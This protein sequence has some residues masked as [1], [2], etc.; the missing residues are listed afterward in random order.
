MTQRNIDS[1]IKNALL[2]ND[3]FI[4]AHLVKFER[5]YDQIS[6]GVYPTDGERYAYYTDGATD[7]VFNDG[8]GEQTYR[9]N[10]IQSVGQYSETTRARA[11]T[12]S[13]VLAGED[14]GGEVAVTGTITAT[15]S[16]TGFITATSTVVNGEALDF[17][18]Y[19]FKENDE[20]SVKYGS[21]S[22]IFRITGFTSNNTVIQIKSPG[23]ETN[24]VVQAQSSTTITIRQAS[25][26]L[27]AALQERST[28]ES[29]PRFVN[30][31][32]FIH[33]VFINPETGT[34]LGNKS[35]LVFK[36][37][38][39]S[40]NL[41]EGT[42]G[43]KVKWGL[44]SHWGDFEEVNG[45]LTT[46]ETHRA[47][48]A[49]NIPQ[50]SSVLRPEYAT[51]LGFMHSETSLS[52]IANYLTQETRYKSKQKKR[53]GVA[54][55]FGGKK[56]ELIEYQV[57][58][59]NEVDLNVHLQGKYLPIIYGVQRVNGNT[60]FADTLNNDDKA[61]Y[62]VDAICE[63]EIHGLFN[64]YIDDV[65]LICTDENDFDVRNAQSGTD[66]DNTQLQCFGKMSRGNTLAGTVYSGNS[67]NSNQVNSDFSVS[68]EKTMNV[69]DETGQNFS[70]LIPLNLDTQIGGNI[71]ALA[72][73]DASGL[74]HGATFNVE[75]PMSISHQFFHGRANQLASSILTNIAEFT[76]G[77]GSV[78]VIN[79]G[80]NF[81]GTPTITF[82]APPSGGVRATGT[83]RMGSSSTNDANQIRSITVS[84][85]GSGYVSRPTITISQSNKGASLRANMGGFKRQ[86]DYWEGNL[87]YWGPNHRLLDTAYAATKF[88]VDPDSTT[89]PEIEYVVKGKVLDSYNYDN[90]FVPDV[91]SG[92]TNSQANNFSEGDLVLVQY[93]DGSAWQDDTSG[94][95]TANKFKIMDKW[96]HTTSRGTTEYRFRLDTTPNLGIT[97]ATRRA[98]RT[99]LRFKDGSNF[100]YMLT[101][102]YSF[103]D[104]KTFPNEW[105]AIGNNIS[106]PSGVITLSSISAANKAIIGDDP[107][108]QFYD[109]AWYTT[110]SNSSSGLKYGIL[111]G[112][113]SGS[114]DA[115][116][117]TF[118]GTNYTNA[119][120]S[121]NLKI[122]NA[123]QY[124][125]ST[126]SE[127]AA[128]SNTA[129]LTSSFTDSQS[130]TIFAKGSILTNKNTGESREITSFNTT[131]NVLEIEAPFLTPAYS[132]HKFKID[133]RGADKRALSNPALQ[134]LDFIKD[135]KYGRGLKEDDLDIGSF[136]NSA[137]L[138]DARS[139]ITIKLASDPSGIAI[140]DIFKATTTGASNGAFLA[141]G[142]VSA[143]DTTNNTMTLTKVINKFAKKY[144][145]YTSIVTGDIVYRGDTGAYHR[146][147][148]NIPL[149]P[150]TFTG[151]NLG[152]A[153]SSVTLHKSSGTGSLSSI[154]MDIT[155]AIPIDYALYDS[156]WVKYWRYF[157]WE[158]HHQR[159][160]VRH[161]TNFILDTGKSVF[162]NINS[163]L[164][165]FNGI[166][167]YENG[168]YVLDVETQEAAPV[169]S[170]SNG[171]NQNPY[172]IDKTDII[173]N[174]TVN[175][176]SQKN[177]KNTIKASLADPQLNWGSRSV[178]FFNSNF[179][180]ADRNIVK[181]G[182]FPFT[183]I[184]NYYNARINTEKELFQSRFSKEVS[185][186]L[187][188]KAL[189]LRAG[190]VLSINYPPFEWSN[191]LFRIE[192]LSFQ[193]DCSVSV[194]CREY[195]DSI[196]EIT[197]QQ[198]SGV[199]SELSRQH[200]I[201]APAPPT[202]L[203]A[204]TN[205]AG[206]ILLSWS[207]SD[208]FLD[209]S[210]NTEVYCATSNDRSHASLQHLTT[211]T[212]ASTSYMYNAATDE[213]KYF[214]IKHTRTAKAVTGN[215]E[216]LVKSSFFPSG[217]TSGITGTS[218][219]L[220]GGGIGAKV[221]QLTSDDY[222]IV[223]NQ[224]GASPSPSNT[225]TLTADTQGFD[226]PHFLF[227]GSSQ[228]NG[229]AET[230]YGDGSA[231]A[232]DTH[233]FNVPSGHFTD[234]ISIKVSVQ[235]GTSGGEVAFDT[236]SIF[237]VKPGADSSDLADD[238]YTVICSNE[239]HTM[240]ANTAG[241]I[242]SFSGSGTRF[243]VFKGAT[244]LQG[245]IDSGNP[246]SGQYKI[247]ASGTN[248]T[249]SDAAGSSLD[250]KAVVFADHDTM[251]ATT[252]KIIYTISLEGTSNTVTKQQS[253]ATS[254]R[255]AT[256]GNAK[257]VVVTP[258]TNVMIQEVSN[259]VDVPDD[260]FTPSVIDIT[261][262]TANTTTDGTWTTNT[263]SLTNIVNGHA[264]PSCRV[265]SSTISDGM[266]VKYTLASADGS[267]E[268]ST[269]LH[270]VQ[271]QGKAIT[272][273]LTNEAHVFAA[274]T[275]GA[276]SDTSGSG[277]DIE[278]YQGSSKLDFDGAGTSNGHWKVVLAN[279][280]NIT[281]GA[282]STLGTGHGRSARVAAHTSP[283]TGTD[284]FV[285]TYTITGKS[286][287][288]AAFSFVKIQSL[289]KSKTGGT[290]G[291]GA[292]GQSNAI[293]YAYQRSATTLSSNPGAVT[294]SLTGTTSGTITTGSL[295]NGWSK[296]IPS[297]SNPLYVCAATAAGNGSTDTVA[298]NEWSSAVIL[299]N[300]G[301]D[302]DD[303]LNSATIFL[304]QNNNTGSAPSSLPSGAATY[305][306]ASSSLGNFAS[307][308][309][310]WSTTNPGVTDSNNYLWV[311]SATAVARTSTDVIPDS[312]WA[313]I[314]LLAQN[315]DEGS[316]GIRTAL[317]YA[318]QRSA[319]NVT[320]NP[321]DV[322][323]TL[324]SGLIT[325]PSNNN[326]GNSW[327][328]AIPATD[329]NPLY[330]CAASAAGTGTTD[331]IA[332][333]EWSS[334]VKFVEDGEQ[335]ATGNSVA[336]VAI[337]KQ[338]NVGV[339][340]PSISGTSN[341]NFTS[342][343][344]TSLPAGWS[345]TAPTFNYLKTIWQSE[346]A[347]TGTGTSNTVTWPAA[348]LYSP[349]FDLNPNIFQRSVN[350][351]STPS[352]AIANPPSGWSST[353]PSGSNPIWQSTGNFNFGLSG[354]TYNW[355]APQK[356]S[357]DTG[358]AG[359][360]SATIVLYKLTTSS[361]QPDHPNSVLTWNFANKAFTDD[362]SELDGWSVNE[363][364]SASDNNYIWSCSATA[365][366][367]TATDDIAVAEW[368]DEALIR[369]PK[370]VRTALGTLYHAGTTSSVTAAP[371][372]S[373]VSYNFD[374][375]VFS[376]SNFNGWSTNIPIP[377]YSHV[378]YKVTEATF[379]GTQTITLGTSRY[380]SELIK[381]P[382]G[383]FELEYDD[384]NDRFQ[385]KFGSDLL[386]NLNIPNDIKNSQI[387][388]S[389]LGGATTGSIPTFTSGSAV[390]TNG[391]APNGSTYRRTTTPNE[392]YTS[393]GSAW[394]LLTINTDT[395]FTLPAD[396]L[397]GTISVSGTT[398]TVPKNDG[399]SYTFETQDTNTVPTAASGS[400]LP[401][402][403]GLTVGE[404]FARDDGVLFIATAAD[405]WVE[406][407]NSTGDT[408]YSAG[409]GI[410]VSGTTINNSGVTQITA[411][412]N[413]SISAGTG[414]VTITATNT[415]LSDAQVRS[416]FSA[417]SNVSINS[418]GVISA[419]DTNTQLSDAQVTTMITNSDLNMGSNDIITT[420]K[421]LYSNLYSSESDLN[422]NANPSTY[423]G[424]FAHVHN[425]GLA[426]YAHGGAWYPLARL[427]APAFTGGIGVTGAI[428]ASADITA[429][430]DKKLKD[431]I[432][433]LDGSKV[434]D[435]RGVSFTRNDQDDKL[436]SGV[437][438]QELE[439]IAPELVHED[440]D[441][442]K[443]VAYGNV[444]GY[445][446]EAVKL[447]K[448]E[449]EELKS[450]TTR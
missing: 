188:P 30:R 358:T 367:N 81:S 104:D 383:D 151:A 189:L 22:K 289:S 283:A 47:L 351:P 63:G 300:T 375:G 35:V 448:E 62:T 432:V 78:E 266:I 318:Y 450:G 296:T 265:T 449:I 238:A 83:V 128:I 236:I 57:D 135:K 158:H 147:A 401:S 391:S 144:S 400:T 130:N 268:D 9:A 413:I 26:E 421:M 61:V 218:G 256:G 141:E 49:E 120:F 205:K 207:N 223:Y 373:G 34:I 75:S 208:E 176:N 372:T 31:E 101:W 403:S 172:Y 64:M 331:T 23:T 95:H 142:V 258:T 103:V 20:I 444:V 139:D 445:L 319:S 134:T 97:S 357:G 153:L 249:V 99:Q 36:G 370:N 195:D 250:S 342:G 224:A 166:L 376:G 317:V 108:V 186:K 192:N 131:T 431:N 126:I 427:N 190:Q 3:D 419:T 247:S 184:T 271:F 111:K 239:A 368:S 417:G 212:G 329:G 94:L 394:T 374:T 197:T 259:P 169:P 254:Q 204:S 90:T 137:K 163:L 219:P 58:I 37:L 337:Y 386:S 364:P 393:N 244:E 298:A 59:Q 385:L 5:A 414:N 311:T 161:Q 366:A 387:S 301:E 332:A 87:P 299:T 392:L 282:I 287:E 2:A 198:A 240:P 263:G 327:K 82:S 355:T 261:A 255:G 306:F 160:V 56:Q 193:A 409:T 165:H 436:S 406:A 173:G 251:N 206:S 174:I 272:P 217:A 279:T 312:E 446:I 146:A 379:G 70:Q 313:T 360:N 425:T 24:F 45:R 363:V 152:S 398:V 129:E 325:A 286:M 227:N 115:N 309:N 352:T 93:W 124:N 12:M 305:T 80:S 125:M 404:T 39:A 41:V 434:F 38:I 395:V 60:V 365:A 328:K 447:L 51:D 194:K 292:A 322:T 228:L 107:F 437:I 178:T 116:V 209:S 276:V 85:H 389:G 280:A 269:S 334:P 380:V 323:V 324:T 110:T 397:K 440:K 304:Y 399:S 423:H 148:A 187:G 424:M 66:R 384:S 248:I 96:L 443:G 65:P 396:V 16:T 435:M 344:L 98:T 156:D 416:K 202:A 10:R 428:V 21:T 1:T 164:S 429:F 377:A 203:T 359:L 102:D 19:G 76:D 175:D 340:R 220:S 290:G 11:T 237:A 226:N 310:G 168:K 291:P 18:D 71:L 378:D 118:A 117:L 336:L 92:A 288:G 231:G 112:T 411:G 353:I 50:L 67:S 438:A 422:S 243:E 362:S 418:S 88:Q 106:L 369:S 232:K 122:R 252:A 28:T 308:A 210:D 29:S 84:N 260:I 390:P 350:Q 54:G 307:N 273:L 234:P 262:Q 407:A 114:G 382:P 320:S 281:E 167:S 181:T 171:E 356:I 201:E 335:G 7:I 100:W 72:A 17:T 284:N 246:T 267:A 140:G 277:T 74:E 177:G 388:L 371:S 253:F 225:I 345:A 8:N 44:T 347:V 233:V 55:L 6:E 235:E 48:S 278:V 52:A 245:K 222:S 302:G 15:N 229:G 257:I 27:I 297:G 170:Y 216:F 183:G 162:S 321:G 149:P 430:S 433:T 121:N 294:V 199:S 346:V 109:P 402:E 349:F 442:T 213:T 415:Q 69:T 105:V 196:Y 185:F 133:G 33:K 53:G 314:R 13:L 230:S 295:A 215:K 14:I 73:G 91:V 214:W 341:Y 264:N 410:T 330:V 242:T 315:G 180:K 275:N 132:D 68:Q 40:T 119:S 408:T 405:N 182:S 77:V 42:T 293:V 113:W 46:D 326:L 155:N 270:L 361:T 179:L 25:M 441:G 426:Y 154:N 32:V 4:Y 123:I 191:K 200:S 127:I 420:G 136:I 285:M 43:V 348:E 303:G 211:I 86:T 150:K 241:T 381:R 89:I 138:C 412:S 339:A 316:P 354:S 157:G 338:E 274:A 221:V 159:E 145:E 439:K 79:K 143:I 333:A 343:A